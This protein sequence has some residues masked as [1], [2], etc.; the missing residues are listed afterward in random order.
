MRNAY[1][2]LTLTALVVVGVPPAQARPQ[3]AL[4]SPVPGVLCDRYV[5]ANAQGLSREL[6]ATHVSKRAADA[7]FAYRNTD[8]SAFT[9]ANGVF[10][11]VKARQCRK[12]RYFGPDG[13]PSGAIQYR[14]TRLL[15]GA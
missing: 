14:Y 4:R 10:C 9:F 12:N 1:L 7:A 13:Q 5:C 2:S 6:T 11:D 15:F 8:I 3:A